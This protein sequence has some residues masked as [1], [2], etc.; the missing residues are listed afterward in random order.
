MN[1][2]ISEN[3]DGGDAIDRILA[4][5]DMRIAQLARDRAA[6]AERRR[7]LA[8][9]DF[10]MVAATPTEIHHKIT[11]GGVMIHYGLAAED[12]DALAGMLAHDAVEVLALCQEA[13]D[14]E[15]G[16]SFGSIL[17]AAIDL[18]LRPLAARGQ[19]ETWCRRLHAY[20][21]DRSDWLERDEQMRLDGAW[22]E[23]SMTTDQR[24][25]IRATCRSR[26]IDL[27]GHLSRGDAA[28]WLEAN[29]AN[30]S[31]RDFVA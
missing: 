26:R 6:I 24:W 7:A 5:A 2:E 16:I 19:F 18:H 8:E 3:A 29:G 21:A 25:L 9:P 31:Y 28:E 15:Y 4:D 10:K 11:L 20:Q 14:E 30:L 23:L 27:P 12:A 1:S 17:V 22:R 13:I